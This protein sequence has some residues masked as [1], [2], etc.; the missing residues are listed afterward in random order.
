MVVAIEDWIAQQSNLKQTCEQIL[1]KT[2]SL[3]SWYNWERI[4]G[5]VYSQGQKLKER[6]YTDEQTQ[7]LL[8][9]AWY[10]KHHSRALITY[11]SARA[12]WR[13]NTYRIEEVFD[14]WC[15]AVNN[16]PKKEQ[17]IELISLAKV[18]QYCNTIANRILSRECWSNWKKHLGIPKYAKLIEEGKASLLVF[19][20]CWRHDNPTEAFPSVR[21]L[22]V[23]MG[24]YSR[25]AMTLD[26]ASS[27]KM[28]YR[29]E[30]QGCLGRDLPRYLAYHGYKVATRTLYTWKEFHSR[31]HYSPFELIEWK[32][33]A[34]E[35]MYGT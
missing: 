33:L 1:G 8:C 35:K 22:S 25:R 32:N 30:M 11:N 23:L 17:I 18:K 19:M 2:I 20:A 29:W 10:R 5:A 6:K 4:C 27:A 13:S 31:K 12:Y 16:P 21:R 15:H 26:T 34:K 7:L 24:E 9:L 3:R 14:A 28:Q